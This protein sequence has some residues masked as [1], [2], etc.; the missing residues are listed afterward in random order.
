MP[1]AKG[2]S[3]YFVAILVKPDLEAVVTAIKQECAN[4]YD[5]AYALRLPAHIT[6]VP[7]FELA[8]SEVA[9]VE[10]AI[11]NSIA[12]IP[13][14]TI[15]LKDFGH[16]ADRVIYI[17]VEPNDILNSVQKLLINELKGYYNQQYHLRAFN[18]HLTIANRDLKKKYFAPAWAD[19]GARKFS[20]LFLFE[21]VA[22]LKHVNG[23]W[24]L[25]TAFPLNPIV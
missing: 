21:E 17:G 8:D 24:Q 15:K 11:T 25:H 22:L 3:L 2:S 5:A 18:P 14:T 13:Q 1:P 9:A 7:P 19:F 23:Y 10:N 20:H 4:K 16:F 12:T 6:L